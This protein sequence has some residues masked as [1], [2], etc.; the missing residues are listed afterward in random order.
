MLVSLCILS[1]VRQSET[2]LGISQLYQ[3]ENMF[4]TD[5]MHILRAEKRG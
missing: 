5:F 1:S 4:R 2:T 3:N